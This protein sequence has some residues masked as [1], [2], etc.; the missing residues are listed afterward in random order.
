MCTKP[1]SCFRYN[2]QSMPALELI[3]ESRELSK[4]GNA[5]AHRYSCLLHKTSGWSQRR[6]HATEYQCADTT[7][8]TILEEMK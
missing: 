8:K 5:Q 1:L 7:E 4:N 2:Y 3:H 6:T